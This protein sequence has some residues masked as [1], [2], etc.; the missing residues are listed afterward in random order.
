[1][2]TAQIRWSAVAA[3]CPK[4]SARIGDGICGSSS[5]S[6]IR[7]AG[8]NRK[9]LQVSSGCSSSCRTTICV[10]SLYGLVRHLSLTSTSLT[11][12]RSLGLQR[13][14]RSFFSLAGC[15][16]LTGAVDRLRQVQLDFSMLSHQSSTK[17]A[18]RQ[19]FLAS[20]LANRFPNRVLH[21]PVRITKHGLSAV[22]S[23]QRTRSFL[24]G[25]LSVAV[26]RMVGTN[27][28]SFFEN[29]VVSFNL[30]IATQVVGAAA[31]RT[32]H[33]RVFRDLSD[34]LSL[35]LGA[36]IEVANPF[37]WLTK[38]EVAGR[39]KALGHADLARHSISC[40]GVYNIT[41]VH[42]HC[43]CCSQCLDRRFGT[44]QLAMEKTIRRKCTI[45]IF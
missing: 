25:A 5:Q 41:R 45:P 35:L 28:L 11:I 29:G 27:R 34:F 36:E 2:S 26:A 43:G 38:A 19:K 21:V 10:L 6:A 22:E 40:S 1:M 44:L 20:E 24:F 9:Y 8:P 16:S 12:T 32:T 30:P 17:I 13:P 14:K 15:D 37:L 23:T 31:T 18:E 39:L 4:H 3:I 42:T 7:T 33:P